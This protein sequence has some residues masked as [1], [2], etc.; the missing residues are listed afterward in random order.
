MVALLIVANQYG[1]NPCTKEIYAFPAK[2]GGIVPIVGIDGWNR[3]ISENPKFEGEEVKYS[4]DEIEING[5]MLPEWCEC[6]IYRKD[7]KVPI[8]HREYLEEVYRDTEPWKKNPRRML[9]HKARIQCARQAFGYGGIYEPDESERIHDMSMEVKVESENAKKAPTILPR[10]IET[11]QAMEQPA[12]VAAVEE[13]KQE[14][15]KMSPDAQEF[16]D[17]L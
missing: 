10:R 8:V 16:A 14:E 13:P 1:L 3:I 17:K 2:G 12:S 15:I 5:R 6:T 4:E 11:A 7:R 9:K